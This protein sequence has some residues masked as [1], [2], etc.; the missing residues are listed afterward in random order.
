MDPIAQRPSCEFFGGNLY[1][2]RQDTPA[3]VFD[4]WILRHDRQLPCSG[5]GDQVQFLLSHGHL[6]F[7]TLIVPMIAEITRAAHYLTD[8]T[9]L[10]APA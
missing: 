6:L 3:L 7:V 1:F 9:M 10:F 8:A 5:S 2:G 4:R